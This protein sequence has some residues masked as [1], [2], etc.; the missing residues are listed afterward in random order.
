MRL[1]TQLSRFLTVGVLNTGVDLAVLNAVTLLT[2]VKDG[3]GYAV[4]KALSFFVAVAFSYVLN[5]RWTFEDA[6]TT[7]RREQF[8]RF[9]LVSIMSAVIN[10]SVATAVATYVKVLASPLLGLDIL[11]DQVWVNIGALSGSGSGLLWNFLGYKFLVFKA[12]E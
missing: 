9:F 8:S 5:K 2:G 10:V 1:V 7:G 4:Q 3:A 11:T 6:S 12:C